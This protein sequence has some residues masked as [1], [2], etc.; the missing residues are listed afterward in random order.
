[1][2]SFYFSGKWTFVYA[3]FLGCCALVPTER[4]SRE[5]SGCADKPVY[6]YFRKRC[7]VKKGKRI[8]YSLFLPRRFSSCCNTTAAII[9]KWYS[10]LL[11][12]LFVCA[13]LPLRVHI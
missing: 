4:S 3:T 7:N 1:V 10:K 12:F 8:T 2:L 6:I 11:L 5:R 9:G 13:V